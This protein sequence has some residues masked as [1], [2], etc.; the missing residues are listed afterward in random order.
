MLAFTRWGFDPPR[1]SLRLVSLAMHALDEMGETAA[2]RHVI[3]GRER[4]GAGLGR[5]GYGDVLAQAFHA[6][7][8]RP[9]ARSA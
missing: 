9:R 6:G 1:E 3:V 8:Y 7:R 5:A 2:G 4:V